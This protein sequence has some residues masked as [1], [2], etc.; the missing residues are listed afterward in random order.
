MM[1]AGLFVQASLV[2]ASVLL[3]GVVVLGERGQW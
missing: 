2:V 3:L 1:A